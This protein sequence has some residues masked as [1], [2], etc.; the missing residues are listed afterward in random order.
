[1]TRTN[2]KATKA[3][4]LGNSGENKVLLMLN[5]INDPQYNI[6]N[7]MLKDNKGNTHQID[8]I[9]ITSAGVFVTQFD[10]KTTK[11]MGKMTPNI[12]HMI[13]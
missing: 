2:I 5:S 13:G 10:E 7:I 4:K 8:L 11:Y 1:M 3:Y 6:H 12:G 9:C